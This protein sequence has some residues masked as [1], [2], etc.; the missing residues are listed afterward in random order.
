MIGQTISHYKI[1]SKLGEGGMSVVYKAEDTRLKRTVALKFLTGTAFGDDTEKARFFREAQAAA[2]LDHPNIC[3]VYEIAEAEG[4][5]FIVMAYVAGPSLQGRIGGEALEL[6]EALD[7]S[8]GIGRGLQAAHENKVVH[9]DIKSAN[10]LVT[11]KGEAKITDFGLAH[12]IERGA[13]LPATRQ[14]PACG[15]LF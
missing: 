11:P 9:R 6:E 12:L 15:E 8:I 4:E 3:A 1:L 14:I 5:T 10:I 7:I 2:S 13:N